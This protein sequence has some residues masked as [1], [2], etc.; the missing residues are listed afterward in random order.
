MSLFIKSVFHSSLYLLLE[1]FFRSGQY[2]TSLEFRPKILLGLYIN[3]PLFLAT[4][5]KY[6]SGWTITRIILEF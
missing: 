6:L 2:V 3:F 4:F 5:N 1:I